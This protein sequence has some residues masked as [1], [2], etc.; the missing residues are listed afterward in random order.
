MSRPCVLDDTVARLD[1]CL[2]TSSALQSLHMTDVSCVSTSVTEM[3]C[4]QRQ[5]KAVSTL[6]VS[7]CSLMTY[8]MHT[9]SVTSVTEVRWTGLRGEGLVWLIGAVVCL[10]AAPR[11]QLSVN[12]GNGWPHNALRYH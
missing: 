11:I 4:E 2:I 12:V 8:L 9:S 5:I 7:F 1:V 3:R 6:S 10:L